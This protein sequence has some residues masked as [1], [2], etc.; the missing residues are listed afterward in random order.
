VLFA[1]FF[2]VYGELA[3]FLHEVHQLL[4]VVFKIEVELFSEMLVVNQILV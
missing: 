4:F 1:P 2:S 3:G